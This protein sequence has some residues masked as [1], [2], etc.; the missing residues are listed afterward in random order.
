M[1]TSLEYACSSPCHQLHLETPNRFTPYQMQ[2]TGEFKPQPFAQDL[3]Y[4]NPSLPKLDHEQLGLFCTNVFALWK[5][6]NEALFD[7]K[8]RPPSKTMEITSKIPEE[9]MS[10]RT[11]KERDANTPPNPLGS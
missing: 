8:Q 1:E 11:I 4:P 2:P 7:N 9:V 10:T 5:T 3:R 6:R